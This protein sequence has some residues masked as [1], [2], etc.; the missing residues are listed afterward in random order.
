[1]ADDRTEQPTQRRLEKSREKGQ[2]AISRDFVAAV[3]WMMF[4]WLVLTAGEAWL[5]NSASSAQYLLQRAFAAGDLNPQR[6]IGIMAA[7]ASPHFA[8]FASAGF[9]LLASSLAAHLAVTQLGF[10]AAK[11]A[12][13]F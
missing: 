12:P 5:G 6:L 1:M 4:V 11:I 7:A 13:D 8:S 10:S 9:A 3:Q 2:F